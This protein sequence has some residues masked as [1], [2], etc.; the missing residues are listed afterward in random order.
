MFIALLLENVVLPFAIPSTNSRRLH[1]LKILVMIARRWWV[2][3]LSK[4]RIAINMNIA[5]P[6]IEAQIRIKPIAAQLLELV[7]KPNHL[8]LHI[9]HHEMSEL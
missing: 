9:S 6:T 1:M 7:Y 2:N 3:E 8:F 5:L 4:V